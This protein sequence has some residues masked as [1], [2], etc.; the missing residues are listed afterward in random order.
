VLEEV[1]VMI[2]G[3]LDIHRAQITYD[4]VDSETGEVS[5]GQI[6]PATRLGLSEWLR[7]R[8]AGRDDVWLAL[9]A[10]TGWR[11]VV[12]ELRRAGI[13]PH[14]AE[15]AET[16]AKRG[17]KQ[18]A[19]TDGADAGHL[20]QLLWEQHFLGGKRL[21]ECW[22]PPLH[23]LEVRTLAR[24]YVSL[25][26]QRKQWLQRVQAQLYHQGVPAIEGVASLPGRMALYQAELSAA[27]RQMVETALQVI[28]AL[29]QQITPLRGQ[30]QGLG[31]AIP[32]A[33]ALKEAHY[34]IGDLIAVIIWSEVGDCRR[35]RHSDQVVRFAGLDVTVYSSAGKRSPGHLSRQG[36]PVLR[37]A[38]YEAAESAARKS[39]PEHA[40][41]EAAHKRHRGGKRATISIARMLAR[42]CY[43][44]LRDLGD[45]ALAP[46]Q[47]KQAA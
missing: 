31:R 11:F 46:A 33:R 21:P 20:R 42:R 39:S 47:E 15:P 22:I 13:E 9:E 17:P 36:S 34:G 25:M 28:S 10:C 12:E 37:W 18:R 19:K 43:H 16:A 45:G 24:L 1:P 2:I 44:S 40:Y 29:D 14:L 6:R 27:G 7:G 8:F 4:I 26:A 23:L 5:S 3:G 38:L 35:F 41:Y 32:G 30:L